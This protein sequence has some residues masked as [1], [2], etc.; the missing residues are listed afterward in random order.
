MERCDLLEP[1]FEGSTGTCYLG[2]I[3]SGPHVGRPALL[4][5]LPEPE[6]AKVHAIL[7]VLQALSRPSSTKILCLATAAEKGFI[8]SEYIEGASLLELEMAAG[9]RGEVLPTP[10]L[11]R[12]IREGLLAAH[13][14]Q[15]ML[16]DTGG[17]TVICTL[18]AESIWIAAYGDVYLTELGV[19][20]G[21]LAAAPPRPG[22]PSRGLE[23]N[24]VR[25]A[26]TELSRLLLRERISRSPTPER[27]GLP[28]TIPG[29]VEMALSTRPGHRFSGPATMVEALSLLPSSLLADTEHLASEVSRLVGDKLLKRKA[30]TA[31]T[32]APAPFRLPV[33][34]S[35]QRYDVR[36]MR[37]A[38]KAA[39]ARGIARDRAARSRS[40]DTPVPDRRFEDSEPPRGIVYDAADEEET[41]HYP[42]ADGEE[43]SFDALAY[44]A[45]LEEEA[46]R[47]YDPETVLDAI[48]AVNLGDVSA[49][50]EAG[51]SRDLAPPSDT[52]TPS[53]ASSAAKKDSDARPPT[54][55]LSTSQG[56]QEEPT[57]SGPVAVQ[58]APAFMADGDATEMPDERSS[59]EGSV[60]RDREKQSDKKPG[61]TTAQR[62]AFV[63]LA[64]LRRPLLLWI[65]LIVV[66]I[67]V[68]VLLGAGWP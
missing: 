49:L 40:T 39:L 50:G 23:P 46:T 33:G 62:P 34:D 1:L 6:L 9:A 41:R 52:G 59:P 47:C 29:I 38:F 35:T 42:E 14:T 26:G 16:A 20:A 54:A 64:S 22:A 56:E 67:G 28:V 43:G 18:S 5:P 60:P 53:D 51:I 12:A 63:S 36:Q 61:P 4:R 32:A 65:P 27:P 31:A 13:S 68:L 55:N 24:P 45:P 58:V 7:P 48:E 10:V 57:G 25:A 66:A 17:I 30:L 2:V 8:A 11:T 15:A 37:D 19:I 44:N 3:A 21:M